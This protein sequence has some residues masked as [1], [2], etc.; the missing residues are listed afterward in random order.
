MMTAIGPCSSITSS[1][2]VSINERTTVAAVAALV[3]FMSSATAIGSSPTDV[4]A[5]TA[6]FT[7]ASEL[8]DPTTGDTPGLNVPAGM[9]VPS[10]EINTLADVVASCVNSAGGTAGDSSPCGQLFALTTVGTVPTNTITA[11]INLETNSALIPNTSALYNL[12][13]ATAPFQPELT[14]A[15]PNFETQLTPS[16]GSLPILVSPA[17]V[18]FPTV[19]VGSSSAAQTITVTNNTSSVIGVAAEVIGANAADF[20]S[21]Q[22]SEPN[23]CWSV[24]TISAG[25]SCTYQ[26]TTTPTVSGN[27]NAYLEI[28]TN[29]SNIP[30]Y[31]PLS[32]A[33][34]PEFNGPHASLST[35]LMDFDF[36][37]VTQDLTLTNTGAQYLTVGNIS[38]ET[39]NFV[40]TSN[41]G[42]DWRP[43]LRAPSR[44]WATPPFITSTTP[45]R[46][47]LTINPISP[48]TMLPFLKTSS[49][50]ITARPP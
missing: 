6:A 27:R 5:L 24:Q 20:A 28:S 26:V 35:Y 44:S 4:S 17:S 8:V 23:D 11:L 42:Q 30:Q 32:E 18:T 46:T 45:E 38:T 36:G 9:T 13:T 16:A 34:I 19:A 37:G 43:M 49:L 39:Q 47:G 10:T 15:P 31:I 21:A 7:L 40:A 25:G 1:T 33:A 48:P 50:W 29:A 2:F 41:C 14:L 3:S 12:V 22:S